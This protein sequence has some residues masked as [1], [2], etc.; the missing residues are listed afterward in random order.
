MKHTLRV[1][2]KYA[3][4]LKKLKCTSDNETIS[5]FFLS[6][7]RELESYFGKS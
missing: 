1:N 6:V 3:K 7:K 5:I 4:I 2:A